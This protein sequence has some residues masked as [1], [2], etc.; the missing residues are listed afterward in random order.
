MMELELRFQ[1]ERGVPGV[2]PQ[3]QMPLHV[4]SALLINLILPNHVGV[5]KKKKIHKIALPTSSSEQ[6]G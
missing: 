1:P 5:Q 3:N 4:Q 2:K 6:S